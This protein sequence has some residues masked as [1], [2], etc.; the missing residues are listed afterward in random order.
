VGL[1]PP[2]ALSYKS[3]LVLLEASLRRHGGPVKL[4]RWS[5]QPPLSLLKVPLVVAGVRVGILVV[6]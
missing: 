2:L 4:S 6:L 3:G 1:G 5:P